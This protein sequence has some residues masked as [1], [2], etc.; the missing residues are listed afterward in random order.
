MHDVGKIV[1]IERIF[2]EDE[3]T[4]VRPNPSWNADE[5]L[6][7]KGVFFLKD[8]ARILD[9]KPEE[10]R[11]KARELGEDSYRK[12][13]VRKLFRHWVVRMSVFSKYYREHPASRLNQVDPSWDGNRLL[14]QKGWFLLRDVAAMVPFTAAQLRYQVNR[15]PEA[16]AEMGVW[17]EEALKAY[18]VDMEPFS[19]WVRKFWR[20]E[21][22]IA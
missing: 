16:R 17:K 4:G 11:R 12:I 14:G 1:Q 20:G 22:E 13:G 19:Q 15:N 6:N 2:E 10:I 5:L 9:L 21:R 7:R 18:V 8:V 3:L